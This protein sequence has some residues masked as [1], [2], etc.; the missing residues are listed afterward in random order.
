[1]NISSIGISIEWLITGLIT[2]LVLVVG[3]FGS[4]FIAS[5]KTNFTTIQASLQKM[6]SQ[7]E[8]TG[9]E[10]VRVST[11]QTSLS[12]T[13]EQHGERL[14]NHGERIKLIELHN[15]KCRFPM[16]PENTDHP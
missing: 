2:V 13:V 4:Q 10:L 14:N 12:K 5:V 16:N 7:N 6:V 15:A 8:A 11:E 1:M 3:Y 9:K